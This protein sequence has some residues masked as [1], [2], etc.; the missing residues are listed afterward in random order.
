MIASPQAE[1]T[2][3]SSPVQE[4]TDASGTRGRRRL[5][6]ALLVPL[7]ALGLLATACLPDHS[8]SLIL[9]NDTRE[10]HGVPGLWANETLHKKA[11]SWAEHLARQGRIYHSNLSS[12]TGG[13]WRAIAENVAQ[14]PSIEGANQSFLN[15][16][17]HRRNMLNRAYTNVGVGVA[18]AGKYYYVVHVF[19]G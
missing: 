14:N 4:Q 2:A 7:T 13:G 11:Q 18:K 15:S 1:T 16:P 19:A 3:D 17:A 6:M 10:A 8:I 5:R 12:G 9:L